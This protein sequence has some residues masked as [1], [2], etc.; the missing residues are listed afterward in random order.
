MVLVSAVGSAFLGVK[1]L[2]ASIKIGTYSPKIRNNEDFSLRKT[3]DKI[4]RFC[5]S[6]GLALM[7]VNH[8]T[9]SGIYSYSICNG[10]ESVDETRELLKTIGNFNILGL[11]LISIGVVSTLIS[12]PFEE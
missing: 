12:R 6:S 5:C 2:E 8:L 7:G 1:F 11:G 9:E 10:K 3:V 4:G